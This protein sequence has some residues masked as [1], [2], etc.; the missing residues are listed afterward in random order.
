MACVF[1]TPTAKA[2]IARVERAP[3]NILTS[4]PK[5][6]IGDVE[7]VG[8][9]GAIEGCATTLFLNSISCCSM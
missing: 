7:G 4:F 6:P 2:K 3:A 9:T 1:K 8:D 5:E